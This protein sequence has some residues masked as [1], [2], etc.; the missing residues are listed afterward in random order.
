MSVSSAGM[1]RPSGMGNARE[2][3]LIWRCLYNGWSDFYEETYPHS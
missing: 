3:A 2:L 1:R